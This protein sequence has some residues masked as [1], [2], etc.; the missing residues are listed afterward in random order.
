MR[1]CASAHPPRMGFKARIGMGEIPD[2]PVPQMRSPARAARLAWIGQKIVCPGGEVQRRY[3]TRRR[4]CEVWSEPDAPPEMQDPVH[5][6][7][8]PGVAMQQGR[9]RAT[10]ARGRKDEA[11]RLHARHRRPESAGVLIGVRRFYLGAGTVAVLRARRRLRHIRRKRKVFARCRARGR[12]FQRRGFLT[13]RC[14]IARCAMQ[15]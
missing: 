4:V 9:R 11:V 8:D 5:E 7:L 3:R 14:F 10:A 2:Q 13:R 1:L 15:D 12:V 6:R